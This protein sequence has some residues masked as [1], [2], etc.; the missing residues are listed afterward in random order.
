MNENETRG[1]KRKARGGGIVEE[2]GIE[3]VEKTYD[4]SPNTL[5]VNIQFSRFPDI[6]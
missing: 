2:E 3:R 6:Y 1:V 5:P 4:W